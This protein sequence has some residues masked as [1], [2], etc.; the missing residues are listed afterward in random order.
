MKGL[1]F[2]IQRSD[3]PVEIEMDSIVAFK[4]IRAKEIDRSVYSSLIMEIRHL[5]SLRDSCITHINRTQNKVSDSLA[6]FAR[7]E[8]RTMTWVGSGPSVSLEL[9]EAD[10]MDI[11]I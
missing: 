10:C 11:E 7:Q 8:G 4:L 1:L 2:A 9:A 3:L 6:K 5:M